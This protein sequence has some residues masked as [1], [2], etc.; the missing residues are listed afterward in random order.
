MDQE[1]KRIR[2]VPVGVAIVVINLKAESLRFLDGE[3]NFGRA[4]FV[5]VDQ[6]VKLATTTCR[7]T[8]VARDRPKP[9]HPIRKAFGVTVEDRIW[10][11]TGNLHPGVKISLIEEI[12]A[13]VNT[14][15]CGI[16][17]QRPLD[18]SDHLFKAFAFKE[19]GVVFPLGPDIWIHGFHH[20]RVTTEQGF[21][22]VDNFAG[23]EIDLGQA[24][25]GERA[26][27]AGKEAEVPNKFR[28][29][30]VTALVE[31]QEDSVKSV[32]NRANVIFL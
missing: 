3:Y 1:R 7:Q 21:G 24:I 13:N 27:P 20:G 2:A 10:K 17:G 6:V 22:T 23:E 9:F 5:L 19:I 29:F 16:R 18:Q 4:K 26:S 11:L 14:D 28:K 25:L 32:C 8:V 30:G 15:V 31:L 12:S